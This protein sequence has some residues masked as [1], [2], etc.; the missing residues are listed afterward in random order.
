MELEQ[1]VCS[2]ELAIK[3]HELGVTK[4]SIFFTDSTQNRNDEIEMWCLVGENG[5]QAANYCPDNLCRYTVAELGEMLPG[6]VHTGNYTQGY[7]WQSHYQV[8]KDDMSGDM[9]YK[10]HEAGETEAD[11]RAKMLVYL[12]EK[13]LIELK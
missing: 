7:R 12:L 11:A 6:T 9:E 13:N 1:Q 8:I 4:P 3:L 10:H 2:L 5:K